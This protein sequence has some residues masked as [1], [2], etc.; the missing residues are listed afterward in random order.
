MGAGESYKEAM[1]REAQEELRLDITQ[2]LYKKIAKLSPQ[3]HGVLCHC[4]VFLV[5]INDMQTFDFN[6]QDIY[7][8][9]WM[10]PHE[11]LHAIEQGDKAKSMLPT[12][13][14]YCF[15]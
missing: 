3:E 15:K 2:Y 8:G 7:E 1:I 11:V 9:D 14:K 6:T 4:E 12:I 5:E 13:L 10:F